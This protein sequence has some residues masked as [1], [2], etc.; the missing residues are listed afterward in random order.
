[1]KNALYFI[2]DKQYTYY[3]LI[4]KLHPLFSYIVNEYCLFY[5][6]IWSSAIYILKKECVP[7]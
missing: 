6:E 7:K 4:I 3:T 1:M 5:N 2:K